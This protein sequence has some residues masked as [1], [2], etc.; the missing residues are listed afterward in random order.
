MIKDDIISPFQNIKSE[1]F[2][3]L[4]KFSRWLTRL[5]WMIFVAALLMTIP[6][7]TLTMIVGTQGFTPILYGLD[8]LTFWLT[9]MLFIFISNVTAAIISCEEHLR[10]LNKK[11]Q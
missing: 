7:W 9:P 8:I 6:R 1:N 5:G 11:S 10:E 3:G 2:N 4:L